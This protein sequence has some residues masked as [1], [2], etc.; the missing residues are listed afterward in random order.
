M[1]V[2]NTCCP[3]RSHNI[4]ETCK[5]L[6]GSLFLAASIAIVAIGWSVYAGYNSAQASGAVEIKLIKKEERDSYII[7]QLD[8]IKQEQHTQRKMI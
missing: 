3:Y 4:S 8:E 7:K 1:E 6:F 2:A 5:F